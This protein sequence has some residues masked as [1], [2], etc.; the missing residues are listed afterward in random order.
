MAGKFGSDE[1]LRAGGFGA[2]TP[3]D[4]GYGGSGLAFNQGFG[5]GR[6]YAPADPSPMY[7]YAMQNQR[8]QADYMSM[9]KQQQF[10]SGMLDKQLGERWNEAGLNAQ[11]AREGYG[12]QQQLAKMQFDQSMQ[13]LIQKNQRFNAIM[14]MIRQ[15]LDWAKNQGFGMPG[16]GGGGP[17][18]GYGID[19]KPVYSEDQIQQQVNA[20][21]AANDASTAG[22]THE[23]QQSMAG[24]GYGANSPLAQMLG[25]MY[26][27]QN[28]ATNTANERD[29]RLKASE[30]NAANKVEQGKLSVAA[31]GQQND[32]YASLAQTR[33]SGI[34][35]LLAMLGSLA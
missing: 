6:Y 29:T 2:Y 15:N 34:N 7:S 23:M 30:A 24:R 14:P 16:G 25:N 5:S 22:K 35:A 32:L 20:A 33:Q 10:Q 27:G 1:F 11:I 12:N 26:Q 28:L 18:G 19:N 21:H 13:P 4:R 9:L 8:N 31:Q 17:G 3:G